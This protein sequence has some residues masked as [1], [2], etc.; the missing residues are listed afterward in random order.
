LIKQGCGNI[1]NARTKEI[2]YH[3]IFVSVIG[4][5]NSGIIE[6]KIVLNNQ[7]YKTVNLD[8]LIFM[9]ANLSSC[10]SLQKIFISSGL[11]NQ[12]VIHLDNLNMLLNRLTIFCLKASGSSS[13]FR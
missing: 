12:A 13:R 10:L 4:G 11:P 3:D 6:N 7:G 8:N 2:P 5:L 9:P 1:T